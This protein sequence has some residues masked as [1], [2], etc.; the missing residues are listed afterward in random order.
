M[1][2]YTT[3]ETRDT[4]YRLDLPGTTF[5]LFFVS[6]L[7]DGGSFASAQRETGQRE[8]NWCAGLQLAGPA[9]RAQH[10]SDCTHVREW[11]RRFSIY[12]CRL[13]ISGR[14]FGTNFLG[15]GRAVGDMHGKATGAFFLCN[16]QL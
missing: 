1:T 15:R 13:F 2:G 10:A 11:V 3:S 9:L 7:L 16:N 6:W 5:L 12:L 4:H 14:Y 8:E